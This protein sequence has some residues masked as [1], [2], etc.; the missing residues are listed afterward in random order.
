MASSY[1]F[2]CSQLIIKRR[3]RSRE[4]FGKEMHEVVI[5]Y[6]KEQLEYLL[7]TAD[8][9]GIALAQYVGQIKY[10]VPQH[11][12]LKFAEETEIIFPSKVAL[13]PISDALLVFT[14]GSSNGTSATY[15]K[16]RPVVIKKA[17][18]T[19][20]QQ[21]EIIAVI[22]ALEH[23]PEEFNLYTDSKYVVHLFPDIETALISGSSR[24]I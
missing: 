9:W 23:L 6:D 3:I 22:T 4:L 7:Q 14:D 18:E 11:P 20:A 19:S 2:M 12:I 17:K 21:V 5:P 8:D 1:P 10:H 15:I 24:I 16:D 13:E